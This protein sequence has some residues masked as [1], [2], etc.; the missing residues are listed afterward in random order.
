MGAVLM[1]ERTWYNESKDEYYMAILERGCN[2]PVHL[3]VRLTQEQADKLDELVEM[4]Y[5]DR[6][7]II[8][9]LIEAAHATGSPDLTLDEGGLP[10]VKS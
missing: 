8:R 6:S 4:T 5:R 3:R 2:Y 10:W 1:Q 7:T 9:L